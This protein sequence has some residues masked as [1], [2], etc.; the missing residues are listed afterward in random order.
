[1][2][3]TRC[4][5][6][7]QFDE[8]SDTAKDTARDWYRQGALDYDWWDS[9]YEDAKR[10]G[11]EITEFDLDRNKHVAGHLTMTA[12]ESI[13]AILKDHGKDCD[14]FKMAEQFQVG[15]KTLDEKSEDYESELE[16]FTEEYE[17]A[18]CEE[19]ASVLQNEYEWQLADEQVDES[20]RANEYEF[21]EDG[22]RY[23][24]R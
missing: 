5:L 14:T 11:L 4:K 24:Y 10:V 9:T 15:L 13:K 21:T 3:K 8:L 1:M 12:E 19:Y 20:I 16:D 22:N 2:P 7:Y 23:R 17:K 18:L 6:V